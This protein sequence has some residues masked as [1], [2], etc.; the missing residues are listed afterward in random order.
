MLVHRAK[1]VHLELLVK[2]AVQDHRALRVFAVS[3]E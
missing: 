2:M 3:L 1:L